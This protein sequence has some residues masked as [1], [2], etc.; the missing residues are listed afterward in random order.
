LQWPLIIWDDA[1]EPP[2]RLWIPALQSLLCVFVCV[3]SE[4]Y[5]PLEQ[6][7]TLF[8]VASIGSIFDSLFGS[9]PLSG[10]LRVKCIARLGTLSIGL[11][12][13]C[14]RTMGNYRRKIALLVYSDQP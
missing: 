8:R 9:N 13:A 6:I 7:Y 12:S 5:D 4:I 10:P 14:M 11:G 2:W 1:P 3:S